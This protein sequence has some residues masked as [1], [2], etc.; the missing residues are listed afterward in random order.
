MKHRAC[1]GQPLWNL[2]TVINLIGA[3]RTRSG[4]RVKAVL[5][6][7]R[8]EIGVKISD[9]QIDKHRIRRFRFHPDWNYT[10]L[11]QICDQRA[12]REAESS[13]IAFLSDTL[14]IMSMI[15]V[16]MNAGRDAS[17]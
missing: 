2:E 11:H 8:Y 15:H 9:E 12:T 6:T 1:Y 14:R 3:T 10:I 7:G 13:V 4:L 5:D 17:S 16:R